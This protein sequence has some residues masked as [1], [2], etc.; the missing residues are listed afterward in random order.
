MTCAVGAS[1]ACQASGV[2]TL[3]PPPVEA[4]G[5]VYG[6]RPLEL[7]R[8]AGLRIKVGAEGWVG[9]FDTRLLS[10]YR[11]AQGRPKELV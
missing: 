11:R 4:L 5:A 8:Q 10:G 6:F 9:S 1:R 7:A 3:L 2:P